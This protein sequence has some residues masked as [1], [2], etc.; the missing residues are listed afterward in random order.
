[1]DYLC[2]ICREPMICHRD[3]MDGHTLLEESQ[4]CPR[5]HY[6]WEYAYGYTKIYVEGFNEWGYSYNTP[7]D[8]VARIEREIDQAVAELKEQFPIFSRKS[9]RILQLSEED[10]AQDELTALETVSRFVEEIKKTNDYIFVGI[11][12]GASGAVAFLC[13]TKHCVV[14]IPVIELK[15]KK[16]VATSKLKGKKLAAF[17]AKWQDVGKKP[18]TITVDG[19]TTQYDFPGI[20]GLFRTFRRDNGLRD[21][22]VVSLE[23]AQVQTHKKLRQTLQTAY[24]VGL[25]YG[26]WLLWLAEKGFA[27]EKY[28]PITWKRAMGL[29]GKDK[30]A[31]LQMARSLWPRA[32]LTRAGDHNRAEALLLAEYARRQRFAST[33]T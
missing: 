29:G 1:M 4:L 15:I 30:K 17:E 10:V 13:G 5:N 9:R 12:P 11:D 14:D 18:K 8:E 23:I 22:V 21:R 16:S 6:Y 27:A 3:T 31:S 19:T 24:R 2:P 26:I 7:R 32:P 20:V 25:G 28:N 33:L